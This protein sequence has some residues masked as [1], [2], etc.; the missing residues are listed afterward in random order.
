LWLLHDFLTDDK[1][2]AALAKAR[3]IRY[4]ISAAAGTARITFFSG[5][6]EE[7]T[8]FRVAV[9]ARILPS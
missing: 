7:V 2:I 1:E 9:L 4:A 3:N 8:S 5:K 6:I